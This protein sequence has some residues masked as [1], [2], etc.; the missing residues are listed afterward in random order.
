MTPEGKEEG[1]FVLKG[2]APGRKLRLIAEH[3]EKRLRGSA[4]IAA[5]PEASL[6]NEV[7]KLLEEGR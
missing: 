2:L 5:R 1:R 3:K 4:E 7:R 6:E